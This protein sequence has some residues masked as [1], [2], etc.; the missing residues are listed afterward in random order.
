[1]ERLAT[2]AAIVGVFAVCGCTTTGSLNFTAQ[3]AA[4]LARASHAQACGAVET[5]HNAGVLT[6]ERFNEAKRICIQADT[7]LDAAD[8]A[9]I[10]GQDELAGQKI[11]QALDLLSEIKQ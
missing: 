1:M 3:R 10:M 5:S 11:N 9:L 8:A 4:T 7:V 6:G 2:L